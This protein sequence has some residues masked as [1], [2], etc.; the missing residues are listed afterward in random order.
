MEASLQALTA[1]FV[2]EVILFL[3]SFCLYLKWKR[4]FPINKRKPTLVLLQILAIG[5]LSSAV[6]GPVANAGRQVLCFGSMFLFTVLIHIIFTLMAIRIL[7]LWAKDFQT[8]LIAEFHLVGLK[9]EGF[10]EK[11]DWKKRMRFWIFKRSTTVLS[12]LFLSSIV[13]V[14]ESEAIIEFAIQFRRIG[15]PGIYQTYR[16]SACL[17]VVQQVFRPVII[18]YSIILVLFAVIFWRT[19]KIQENFGL[20]KELKSFAFVILAFILLWVTV[21]ISPSVVTQSQFLTNFWLGFVLEVLWLTTSIWPTLY[22]TY[23]HKKQENLNVS[24]NVSRSSFDELPTTNG[25]AIGKVSKR[26]I[27]LKVLNNTEGHESFKRYLQKEF[28]LENLLFWDAVQAL[29]QTHI[30]DPAFQEQFSELVTKFVAKDSI[31]CVNLSHAKREA[32]LKQHG[33]CLDSNLR[34]TM[35]S[36]NVLQ[37]IIDAEQEILLMLVMDSF[38]RF[39]LTP[40]CVELLHKLATAQEGSSDAATI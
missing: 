29:K 30:S 2:I 36:E 3:G 28:A 23:K 35:D 37:S 8:K 20:V 14:E 31:L 25:A 33:L 7:L 17:A 11:S 19:L 18:R 38:T 21:L 26:A 1:C 34:Q 13:L 24:R 10:I 6:I 27:L 9:D 15:G 22:W 39:R 32:V 5:A 12:P 16:D 40:E 4:L